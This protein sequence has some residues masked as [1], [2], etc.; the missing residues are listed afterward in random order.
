MHKDKQ[1]LLEVCE[2]VKI[3]GDNRANDQ[4]NFKIRSGEI[5]ALLGENGAGKS[6]LV[7][8]IFGA[9]LPSSGEIK[10]KGK[11]VAI[12]NPAFAR[13]LGLGMVFQHFSLFESL[14]VAENIRLAVAAEIPAAKLENRVREISLEYGLPLEPDAIV[15]D[16]SAGERQRVEIIRCVLQEPELIILDEPTSVLTPQEAIQLGETLQRLANEGRSILYITHR[17]EEVQRFCQ[18]ATILRDGKVVA[19]CDPRKETAASLASLMVGTTVNKIA[20]P[21]NSKTTGPILLELNQLSST[22]SDQFGVNLKQVCLA[23]HAGELVA[24]AGIAGNGQ[25]EFFNVV[26]G[27]KLTKDNQAIKIFGKNVGQLGITVR[28]KAGAAFA[29]EERIGHAAIALLNLSQNIVLSWHAINNVLVK[30]GLLNK[31]F[32]RKI[33]HQITQEFD[34][35]SNHDDPEAHALSGGN[36]Q[37]FVIGRELYRQPKIL[38]ANQPTWGVDIGAATLIRQA[39]IDLARSGSAV[40]VLSQDLDEI[41]EIADRI[42]VISRGQLSAAEPIELMTRERIGLLMAG[43]T[44][45]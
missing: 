34:V 19:C 16:L 1:T 14:T 10:W 28:R 32:A 11:T 23:V 21:N 31:K 6:T 42:A 12:P 33:Q 26:S 36:L 18:Y 38:V 45:K 43:H 37:K 7:K 29:P 17:L 13:Q 30:F 27:E 35:R 39:L 22:K 2:L 5:H 15:A 9:L 4:I 24:I 40:L 20:K 8:I 25:N 3:F 41:F 44:N